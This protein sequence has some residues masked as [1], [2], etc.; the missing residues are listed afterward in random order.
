MKKTAVTQSE[1]NYHKRLLTHSKSGAFKAP[2]VLGKDA[3]IL[4]KQIGISARLGAA[5]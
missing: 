3:P 1:L 2:G 4:I 5:R